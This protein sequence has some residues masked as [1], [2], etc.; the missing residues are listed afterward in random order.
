MNAKSLQERMGAF[1]EDMG[2]ILNRYY[3][4]GGEYGHDTDDDMT[5]EKETDSEIEYEI[6]EGD[7]EDF[8]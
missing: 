8:K 6:K 4:I 7:Y 1:Y 3:D 5:P 2:N